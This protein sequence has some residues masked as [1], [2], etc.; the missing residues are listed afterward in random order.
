MFHKGE[1][2]EKIV[3]YR[4][5]SILEYSINIGYYGRKMQII[6]LRIDFV[7]PR[8]NKN[9][10]RGF[11]SMTNYHPRY[12]AVEL[13]TFTLFAGGNGTLLIQLFINSAADFRIARSCILIMTES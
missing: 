13:A 8:E 4:S 6:F 9:T 7:C 5:L 1:G 2:E 10:E 12:L 3:K 11:I